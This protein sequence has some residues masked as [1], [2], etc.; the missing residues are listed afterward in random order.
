MSWEYFFM[1]GI[2]LVVIIGNIICIKYPEFAKKYS[3]N[4]TPYKNPYGYQPDDDW[5][6][7]TTGRYDDRSHDTIQGWND[8]Y[9]DPSY[10]NMIG[11]VYNQD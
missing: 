7:D 4:S 8:W 2:G 9:T 5:S 3:I 1:G 6:H 10:S 11:N